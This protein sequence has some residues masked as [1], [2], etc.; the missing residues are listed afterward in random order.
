MSEDHQRKQSALET[1]VSAVRVAQ[2]RGAY[3]LEEASA[4]FAAVD[5]FSERNPSAGQDFSSS[6]DAEQNE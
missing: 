5:E 2:K 6:Q 4:I 3:S 1:L